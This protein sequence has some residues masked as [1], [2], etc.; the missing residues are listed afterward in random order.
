MLGLF[1]V[2]G[3]LFSFSSVNTG[4]L[5]SFTNP[6]VH[7]N[8]CQIT[9]DYNTSVQ[10]STSFNVKIGHS[11]F[12][13]Q[14]STEESTTNLLTFQNDFYGHRHYTNIW[15][16]SNKECNFN[17]AVYHYDIK[18]YTSANTYDEYN[19]YNSYVYQ[20]E[21]PDYISHP[22]CLSIETDFEEGSYT[23]FVRYTYTI[24]FVLLPYDYLIN[25]S[26]DLDT[27]YQSGYGAGYDDGYHEGTID[28]TSSG[29]NSGYEA[30]ESNGH[31]EGYTEGFNDGASGASTYTFTNFFGTIADVPILYV[32][33]LLGFD[34]F[35]VSGVSILMTLITAC[36]V[37]YL[38]RRVIF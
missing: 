22:N 19:Y 26:N 24:D 35:G 10:Q 7:D 17:I 21:N 13:N 28:G 27:V 20:L 30:G 29:Y 38:L 34:V 16:N 2:F 33:N 36:L 11:Y 31:A 9:I 8:M 6:V 15:V 12:T 37:L 1:I 4:P 3:S 18:F 23:D 14:E 32:R 25:S 5:P